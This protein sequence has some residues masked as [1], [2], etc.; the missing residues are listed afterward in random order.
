M[1][2]AIIP[3]QTRSGLFLIKRISIAM[4]ANVSPIKVRLAQINGEICA[5]KEFIDIKRC[6][7]IPVVNTR[8]IHNINMIKRVKF[9]LYGVAIRMKNRLIIIK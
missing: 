4:A 5:A 1:M 8:A 9:I 7:L 3:D 2:A 6:L